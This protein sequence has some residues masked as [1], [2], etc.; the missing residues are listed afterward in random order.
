MGEVRSINKGEYTK[1]DSKNKIT[2]IIVE[3]IDNV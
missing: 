3:T 2:K 1:Y